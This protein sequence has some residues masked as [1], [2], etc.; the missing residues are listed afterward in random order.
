MSNTHITLQFSLTPHT[1][2]KYFGFTDEELDLLEKKTP[3]LIDF[4]K[5]QGKSKKKGKK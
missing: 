2:E 5:L 3:R 1:L 4:E